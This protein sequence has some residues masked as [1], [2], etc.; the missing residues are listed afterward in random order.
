MAAITENTNQ[1]GKAVRYLFDVSITN[2]TP[3]A[4][5]RNFVRTPPWAKYAT[6]YLFHTSQAGTTPLL[7][8]LV[9]VPD[10]STAALLTAPDNGNVGTLGN[11]APTQ[12]TGTGAFQ[13]QVHMGPGVIDDNTGSA[14][15]DASYG[16]NCVL[17]PVISFGYTVDGTTGDED[18]AFLVVVH[19][20]A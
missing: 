19:Y 5:T 12:I 15:A 1:Q 13:Q 11:F 20:R 17:P 14:T 2:Q 7:D 9:E 4:T 18:Y 6:L 16:I 8:I 10:F 3:T